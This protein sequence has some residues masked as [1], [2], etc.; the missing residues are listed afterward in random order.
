MHDSVDYSSFVLVGI[1]SANSLRTNSYPELGSG[2]AGFGQYYWRAFTDQ[3]SG[4]FFTEA[5]VPMLTHEDPRYYTLGKNGFLS[6]TG[7][8]LS[9]V[10]VTKNDAGGSEFN[11]SEIGGNALEAG[12]ANL[13]YPAQERGL[14]KTTENWATQ[15][16]V[17]GAANVLKEFWPDIRRNILRQNN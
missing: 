15:T 11:I 10:V 12:V 13:Y 7:Y 1:L 2:A 9:R 4:T 3:V 17:T 5:I 6:R 8:A 16:I 14:R